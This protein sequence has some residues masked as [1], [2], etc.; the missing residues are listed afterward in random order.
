MREEDCSQHFAGDLT[1]E[2]VIELAE[3]AKTKKRGSKF[4]KVSVLSTHI[5]F[6]KG[7]DCCFEDE[8]K[9]CLCSSLSP[10]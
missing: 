4:A 5:C 8:A 7:F 9:A 3:A 6:S 10:G 1:P 2:N